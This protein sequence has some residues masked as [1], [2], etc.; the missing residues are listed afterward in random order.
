[1]VENLVYIEIPAGT[2]VYQI[3]DQPKN[4]LSIGAIINN[5]PITLTKPWKCLAFYSCCTRKPH[6]F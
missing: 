4:D 5:T 3:S 2:T 1:V 6:L